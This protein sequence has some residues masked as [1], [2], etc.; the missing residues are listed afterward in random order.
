MMQSAWDE[1]AMTLL[2]QDRKDEESTLFAECYRELYENFFTF[3][4]TNT[5]HY[6]KVREYL[7]LATLNTMLNS[8]LSQYVCIPCPKSVID[9]TISRAE[10]WK[11]LFEERTIPEIEENAVEKYAGSL[12]RYLP[13]NVPV[14]KVLDHAKG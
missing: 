9:D 7:R 2:L 11:A 4:I 1:I 10:T 14:D 3:E 6:A 13:E 12:D 5:W 8:V